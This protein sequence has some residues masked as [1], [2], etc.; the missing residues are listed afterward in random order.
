MAKQK[1]E[2][3]SPT[4]EISEAIKK[5]GLPG[6]VKGCRRPGENIDHLCDYPEVTNSKDCPYLQKVAK[7]A[8]Q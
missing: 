8:T 3:L 4:S 7:N 5:K 1:C 6:G 2:Y